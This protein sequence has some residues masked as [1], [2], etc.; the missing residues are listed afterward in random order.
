MQKIFFV[1][2]SDVKMKGVELMKTLIDNG[3]TIQHVVYIPDYKQLLI[4]AYK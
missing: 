2:V 1:D 4:I 3:F